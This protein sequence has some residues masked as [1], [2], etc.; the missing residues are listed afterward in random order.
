MT[1][2]YIFPLL[3]PDFCEFVCSDIAPYMIDEA[4]KTF[5]DI[6]K[7]NFQLLD[8]AGELEDPM[9]GRYDRIFSLYCLMWVA[10]Q[11]KAF[12]NICDLLKPSGECFLVLI[13]KDLFSRIL[14]E[15]MDEPKWE[16]YFKDIRQ[17]YPFPYSKDSDP[18]KT[19]ETRMQ[20]LGFRHIQVNLESADFAFRS[21][22]EYLG[23]LRAIPNPMSKTAP[24]IQ[25]EY[26]KD[27]LMLAKKYKA[28]HESGKNMENGNVL[29]IFARK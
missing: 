18:V 27:A 9:K 12:Q 28:I 25:E 23:F 3:P 16:K 20:R 1:Y 13:R 29:F 14:L 8:I 17:N 24:E 5:K 6:A 26:Q 15:L 2:K 22:E 7:V 19:I 10:D 4:K 11:E 21:E